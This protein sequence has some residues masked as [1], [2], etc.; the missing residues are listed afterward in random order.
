MN[1]LEFANFLKLLQWE[2]KMHFLVGDITHPYFPSYRCVECWISPRIE[3]GG[4]KW[5]L[6]KIV[7]HLPCGIAFLSCLYWLVFASNT[8]CIYLLH[9]LYYDYITSNQIRIELRNQL[10]NCPSKTYDTAILVSNYFFCTFN[11]IHL[12][13]CICI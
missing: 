4:I 10:H 8:T 9:L 6:R 12:G 1:I 11:C 7:H 3:H 5:M 13:I 2:L